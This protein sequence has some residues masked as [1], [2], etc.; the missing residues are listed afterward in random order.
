[1]KERR[2]SQ[3]MQCLCGPIRGVFQVSFLL[4]LLLPSFSFFFFSLFLLLFLSSPPLSSSSSFLR[5]ATERT[6][7]TTR[8][9]NLEKRTA[10][11]RDGAC[12]MDGMRE[13]NEKEEEEMHRSE[14]ENEKEKRRRDWLFFFL[15]FL[16][17]QSP[18]RRREEKNVV[19][20]S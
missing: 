3:G 18:H 10:R 7:L 12:E 14:I 1:M 11:E 15:S 13:E 6:T 20:R 2:R 5:Q 8:I 16:Y 4:L 19:N 9:L 17:P